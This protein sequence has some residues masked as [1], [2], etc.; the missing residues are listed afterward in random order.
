MVIISTNPAMKY[1][2]AVCSPP[3]INQMMFPN[4]FIVT[5]IFKQILSVRR[6]DD[7]K[8]CRVHSL[9]QGKYLPTRFL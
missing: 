4:I 5:I 1:S 9:F 6:K 3:K 8:S 2:M 7:A